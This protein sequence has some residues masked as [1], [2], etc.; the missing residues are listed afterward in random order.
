[1]EGMMIDARTRKEIIKKGKPD[2]KNV[3][4]W[5]EPNFG[6]WY[7]EKEIEA[8]VNA[9]RSSMHWSVGFGP[10]ASEIEAFENAF[11]EYCGV[12]HAIAITNCGVGLDISMMCLDLEPGDEIITPAINY[13]A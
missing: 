11:A 7:T 9:I 8:V 1:M 13:K 5:G 12:K 10:N 4:W 3:P 6:G 2:P